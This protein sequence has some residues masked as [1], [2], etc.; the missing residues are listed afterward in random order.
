[1]RR[2]AAPVAASTT[3]TPFMLAFVNARCVSAAS[4]PV[5]DGNVICN[6]VR[7]RARLHVPT[8]NDPRPGLCRDDDGAVHAL[9][10]D[11]SEV[12]ASPALGLTGMVSP[13][14]SPPSCTAPVLS[15]NA[16]N[17]VCASE[18]LNMRMANDESLL[19]EPLDVSSSSSY[20]FQLSTPL[21]VVT[22]TVAGVA[23]RAAGIS[24]RV[25][26]RVRTP[27]A[28]LVSLFAVA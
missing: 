13:V 27:Y 17:A 1:M 2:T 8:V 21:A 25:A 18:S 19:L 3:R 22:L 28:L 7:K 9:P 20:A 15:K 26:S 14:T 4:T 24:M 12:V 11:V 10:T 16:M 5:V 23:P 6:V